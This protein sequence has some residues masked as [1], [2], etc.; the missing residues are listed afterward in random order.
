MSVVLQVMYVLS[1]DII[2]TFLNL[3]VKALNDTYFKTDGVT[4]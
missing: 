4:F 3:D 1:F 2:T